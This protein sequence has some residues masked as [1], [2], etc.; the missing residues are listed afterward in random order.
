METWSLWTPKSMTSNLNEIV[1]SWI[2]LLYCIF[3]FA[4]MK[5]CTEDRIIKELA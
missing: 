2:Q 5:N 1:R 3:L 4:V